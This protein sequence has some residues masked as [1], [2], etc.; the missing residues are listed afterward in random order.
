MKLNYVEEI[1]DS[2][3]SSDFKNYQIGRQ[4]DKA[5]I[6]DLDGVITDT[7]IFHYLAWATT[8]NA[9]PDLIGK[10][11][12]DVSREIYDE[13]IDGAPREETIRNILRLFGVTCSSKDV[14]VISMYKNSQY[15][16]FVRKNGISLFRDSL[17]LISNL[18]RLGSKL[19]VATSSKNGLEILKIARISQYFDFIAT[20]KEIQRLG[21]KPKP[22]P[23]IFNLVIDKLGI[24]KENVFLFEDSR[25]GLLS[26]IA[27]GCENIIYTDRKSI[28][29]DLSFKYK[30]TNLTK[31]LNLL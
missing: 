13:V 8:F 21:L 2:A 22:S 24:G 5:F 10:P 17:D 18:K 4:D 28:N 15:M 7:T 6:F 26:A 25:V 16:T 27:T 12:I 11:S 31:V 29:M 20:G 1:H 14:E 9:L 19:G 23:D 30:F 3:L